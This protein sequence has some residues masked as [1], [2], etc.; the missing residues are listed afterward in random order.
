VDY[1]LKNRDD[2]STRYVRKVDI[3]QIWK[4]SG[5]DN[6][7]ET[8]MPTGVGVDKEISKEKIESI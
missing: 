3:A 7:I 6:I 2:T 8:S 4:K 5:K 1:A